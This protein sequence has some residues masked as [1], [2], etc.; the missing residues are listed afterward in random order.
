MSI[1][2]DIG[3][4]LQ[5]LDNLPPLRHRVQ[6]QLEGLIAQGRLRPGAR[7]I[8]SDLAKT[9]GTSRGPI[10]EALQLL[11]RDGFID[12]IPRRGTFV[13]TPTDREVDDF[14]DVRRALEGE[15]G[16]L[17]AIRVTADSARKL[18]DSLALSKELVDRG[19][20]PLDQPGGLSLHEQITEVAG[21]AMLSQIHSRLYKR[22]VWYRS[23]FEPARRQQTWAEHEAIVKAIIAGDA[24]AATDRIVM[25]I[26]GA[27]EHCKALRSS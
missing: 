6:E 27:R 21:N 25:H 20:D 15:A 17:A 16:R 18:L 3:T 13:H 11:A 12:L 10:R 5:R 14:F 8:E 19:T 24:E 7:L 4:G 9:L 23:P 2:A 1:D 26:E 22:S